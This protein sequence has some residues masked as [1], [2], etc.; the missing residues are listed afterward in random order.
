MTGHH[1]PGSELLGHQHEEGFRMLLRAA[2]MIGEFD[3]HGG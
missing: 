1:S 3:M 2:Q